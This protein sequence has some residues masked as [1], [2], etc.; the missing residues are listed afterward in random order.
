[1]GLIV[2]AGRENGLAEHTLAAPGLFPKRGVSGRAPPKEHAVPGRTLNN[3]L[4]R[5]AREVAPGWVW[6]R[7]LEG[8]I[9]KFGAAGCVVMRWDHDTVPGAFGGYVEFRL[10]DRGGDVNDGIALAHVEVPYRD[11]VH[12][13]ASFN[14]ALAR[15]IYLARYRS[16]DINERLH[17]ATTNRVRK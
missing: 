10:Y 16:E 8:L 12:L 15:A 14:T 2:G 11:L 4:R 7:D 5:A 13:Q 9:A 1:V 6:S 3:L 17:K